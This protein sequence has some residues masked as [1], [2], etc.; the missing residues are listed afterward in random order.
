MEKV[1]VTYDRIGNTLDVW[2][3][4]PCEAICEEI[5]GSIVIKN[6]KKGELIGFEKLNY[7]SSAKVQRKGISSLPVEVVVA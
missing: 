1:I 5:G 4:K 6:N 3:K 2:F 7:L